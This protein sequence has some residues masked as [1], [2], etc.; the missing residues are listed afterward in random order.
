VMIIIVFVTI[1]AI[2]SSREKGHIPSLSAAI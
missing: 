1:S 2:F